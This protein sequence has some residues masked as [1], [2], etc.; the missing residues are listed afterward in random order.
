MKVLNSRNPDSEPYK[1]FRA[2]INLL[3][4]LGNRVGGNEVDR[5]D[6]AL[7]ASDSAVLVS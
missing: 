7:I 5:V 2:E 6:V 1:R 3:R 4:S